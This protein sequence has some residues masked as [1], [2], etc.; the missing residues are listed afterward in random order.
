M[1]GKPPRIYPWLRIPRPPKFPPIT[2]VLEADGKD[3]FTDSA[4]LYQGILK[5]GLEHSDGFTFTDLGN[6]LIEKLPQ[7]RNY[8]INSKS[9][10]PKSARLANRRQTI[11]EHLDNLIRMELISKSITKAKKTLEDIPSFNLTLEGRFLAWVVEAKDPNKST[12]LMWTLEEKKEK[13]NSKLDP[14]RSKAVKEVFMII[15]SFTSS[16]DS[17][18]LMFLNRFFVKCLSSDYFPRCIDLFYYSYLRDIQMTKGQEL[19][20]LFTKTGHPLNWIYPYP[21]IFIETLDEIQDEEIKKITFF[22]FKMEIEDYYNKYYLMSYFKR[23]FESPNYP[24]ILAISGIEWQLMRFNNIANYTKVVIP[25]F[26]VSCKSENPFTLSLLHYLD[27]LV[28]FTS[29][30]MLD[31]HIQSNCTHCNNEKSVIAEVYVALD[32]FRGHEKL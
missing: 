18:I 24:S 5:Y 21:R 28:K 1:K 32:M 4:L 11:Q 6:W 25:G 23:Y 14:I 15:N 17:C 7:Y 8:Y 2:L 26:C 20:R 16:K 9:H 12:D 3:I 27:Y 29:N 10:I 19:L 30:P 13:I 31:Y 22:Q